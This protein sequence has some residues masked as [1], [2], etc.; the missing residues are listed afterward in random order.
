MTRAEKLRSI[1]SNALGELEKI[2]K[3]INWEANVIP[4][5][6]CKYCRQPILEN[7]FHKNLHL[8]CRCRKFHHIVDVRYGGCTYGER[9]EDNL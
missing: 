6:R 5:L 1:F 3:E 8:V 9:K 2:Y 4:C 7:L